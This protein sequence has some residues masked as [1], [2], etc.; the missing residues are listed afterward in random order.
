MKRE[1]TINLQP[2]YGYPDESKWQIPKATQNILGP[3]SKTIKT[4][5]DISYSK[6]STLE[7]IKYLRY[8]FY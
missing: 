3:K 8:D 5:K 7:S 4:D 2:G 6:Y 1:K